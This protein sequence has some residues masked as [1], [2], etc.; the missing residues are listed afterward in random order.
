MNRT[1]NLDEQGFSLIELL[2]VVAVISIL[3][4]IAIPGFIN[5]RQSANAGSAVAAIRLIN[6][7]QS[8]HL[9]GH[10]RYASLTELGTLGYLHDQNLIGGSKSGYNFAI[11]IYNNIS[12]E[13]TATPAMPGQWQHF[14]VNELGVIH[15][16]IGAPATASSP[17]L[18]R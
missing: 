2:L 7:A 13:A 6:S 5:S 1:T 3:A 18:D 14:F 15:V 12:Y 9:V 10:Y 16:E 4:A 17:L 8:S 11:P